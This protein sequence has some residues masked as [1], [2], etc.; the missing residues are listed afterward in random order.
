MGQTRTDTG[1]QRAAKQRTAERNR[2]P[3]CH[4]GSALVR[5]YDK[6]DEEDGTRVVLTYVNCRWR[7]SNKCDYQT[8][9]DS[10]TRS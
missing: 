7:L 9:L 8:T 6:W 2:C 4:R 1:P 5:D 3:K 10:R